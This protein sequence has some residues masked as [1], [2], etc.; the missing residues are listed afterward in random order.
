M[1]VVWLQNN[2]LF[3]L[4]HLCHDRL[5][6]MVVALK[7]GKAIKPAPELIAAIQLFITGESLELPTSSAPATDEPEEEITIEIPS[8]AV[9]E[10][11]S[12]FRLQKMASRSRC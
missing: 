9:D 8:P 11:E 10:P 4:L 12:V 7:Q 3:D 5:S 6:D 2:Q 1:L